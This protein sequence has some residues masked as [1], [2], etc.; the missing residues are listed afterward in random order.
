MPTSHHATP[1]RVTKL[2]GIALKTAVA[3]LAVVIITT[4]SIIASVVFFG[5]TQTQSLKDHTDN[6]AIH[7]TPSNNQPRARQVTTDMIAPVQIKVDMMEEDLQEVKGDVKALRQE[8]A[9]GFRELRDAIR[10]LE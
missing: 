8:Q 4:I 10:E 9:I 6:E 1:S 5:G 7:E 2:N 3:A